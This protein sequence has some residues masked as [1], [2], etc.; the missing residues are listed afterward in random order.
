MTVCGLPQS[1]DKCLSSLL[2]D[3]TLTSWKI[4]SNDGGG[5]TVT[6]RLQPATTTRHGE[7]NSIAGGWYRKGES[8]ARRDRE[9]WN[10]Y[11]ERF[12]RDSRSPNVEVCEKTNFYSDTCV[13]KGVTEGQVCSGGTSAT[14]AVETEKKKTEKTYQT[15]VEA[16]DFDTE[17]STS[18]SMPEEGLQCPKRVCNRTRTYVTR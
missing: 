17:Q 8:K 5:H 9:R 15:N 18:I 13:S 10:K 1:L 16:S 12:S 2:Q 4:F 11:Q 7:Q 6:I 3:N 14:V